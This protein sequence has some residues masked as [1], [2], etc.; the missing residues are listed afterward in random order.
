VTEP[1]VAQLPVD[2]VEVE[3]CSI[4]EDVETRVACKAVPIPWY[5]NGD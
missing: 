2:T 1:K 4:I 3:D 5:H